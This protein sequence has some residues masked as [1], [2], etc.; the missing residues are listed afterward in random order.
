MIKKF[1]GILEFG[2]SSRTDL[3]EIEGAF[4]IGGRDVLGELEGTIF[5]SPVTIAIADERFTGDLNIELGWGY[6]EW[7]PVELDTLLVG[8]HDIIKIVGQHQEGE[9][10]TLWVA[11]EPVNIIE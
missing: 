9:E 3:N 7:T 10:I 11:D 2:D 5:A 4:L 1:Q 8:E 6:S